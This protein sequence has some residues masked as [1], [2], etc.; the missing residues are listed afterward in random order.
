MQFKDRLEPYTAA[1]IMEATGCK[2]TTAYCWKDGSRAPVA[3]TQD[4]WVKAIADHVE[5]SG[6]L[7][8]GVEPIGGVVG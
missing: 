1:Q 3:W 2:R 6:E 4:K 7:P 8:K 5:E